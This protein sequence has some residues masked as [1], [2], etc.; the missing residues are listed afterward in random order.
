M[1]NHLIY[2]KTVQMFTVL[3]ELKENDD[4]TDLKKEDKRKENTVQK[5]KKQEDDIIQNP[6]KYGQMPVFPH[7]FKVQGRVLI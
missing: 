6:W 7:S 2:D 4:H 3:D 5:K 1:K